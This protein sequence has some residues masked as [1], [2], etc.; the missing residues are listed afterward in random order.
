MTKEDILRLLKEKK[1]FIEKTYSVNKIGLFGSYAKD[2]QTEDSDIDIYVE[3]NKKT[4]DNI[5]G[6]WNFLEKLYRKKIDLIHKH[7]HNNKII[8]QNIQKDI[9]YG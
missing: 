4:F 7:K 1:E 9:I 5:A 8:L 3:F 6:L 2:K